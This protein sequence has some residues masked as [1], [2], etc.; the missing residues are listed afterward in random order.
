MRA[1]LTAGCNTG[2]GAGACANAIDYLWNFGDGTTEVTSSTS[3]DH[4]FRA[5][6]EYVIT[7][8]VQTNTGAN[9]AQRLTLIIQ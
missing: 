8:Q 4:V 7:V 6:G 3:V 1:I 2:F 9:G 5:R